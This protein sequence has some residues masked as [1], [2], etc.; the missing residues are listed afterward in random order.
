MLQGVTVSRPVAMD[1]N[2]SNDDVK[3]PAVSVAMS[4]TVC[5]VT[6]AAKKI[7]T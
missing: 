2:S 1:T 3:T 7:N 5:T 4:L 6:R